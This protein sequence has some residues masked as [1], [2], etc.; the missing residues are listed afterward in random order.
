MGWNGRIEESSSGL[1]TE[2]WQG[3]SMCW[4]WRGS[5]LESWPPD[6]AGVFRNEE[7][8]LVATYG[9]WYSEDI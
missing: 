8:K 7:V 9:R 4:T 5:C 3:S 6:P 2:A 1:R